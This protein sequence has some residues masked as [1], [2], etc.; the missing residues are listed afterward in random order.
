[1]SCKR[2]LIKKL[3]TTFLFRLLLFNIN[4]THFIP[5]YNNYSLKF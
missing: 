2:L 4:H 3:Q 1:M 5:A